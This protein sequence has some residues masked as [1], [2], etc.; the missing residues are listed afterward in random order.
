MTNRI[1]MI[2]ALRAKLAARALPS[3]DLP[4]LGIDRQRIAHQRHATTD[5]RRHAARSRFQ[6]STARPP[7][8]YLRARFAIRP[9]RHVARDAGLTPSWPCCSSGV[10]TK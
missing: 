10:K 2:D 5:R 9:E 3:T 1:Q 8:F 4:T 7:S 6:F